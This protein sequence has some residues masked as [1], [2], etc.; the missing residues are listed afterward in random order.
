MSTAALQARTAPVANAPSS[1]TLVQ[2]QC[3]CGTH[4][5]GGSCESCNH[6]KAG[7]QRAAPPIVQDVLAASG[8]PL[9][10]DTRNRMENH[11]ARDFSGVRVHADGR[12]DRSAGELGARAWTAGAHI[13]FADG[14][15]APKTPKGASLL[16]HELGHVVQQAGATPSRELLVGDADSAHEHEA[17]E[18][19]AGKGGAGALGETMVQR[20]PL[21]GFVNVLLA[22]PHLFGSE[23]FLD[24][25]LKEYLAGLKT[26]HAPQNTTFSDNMARACVTEEAKFGPYDL[27]TK[28][29]LVQEMLTGY[30]SVFDENSIIK[31]LRR[32]P[33]EMPQI[34]AKIGREK[35]WSKFS[36]QNRRIIEALTMTAAD[37]GDVLV[38]KLRAMDASNIQDYSA[39]AT[40]PAVKEA[41]RKALALKKTTV[42]IPSNADVDASGTPST[43]INGVK[44]VALPDVIDPKVGRHAYTEA[45][46]SGSTPSEVSETGPDSDLPVGDPPP[47]VLIVTIHS[48]FASEEQKSLPSKYGVGTRPQDTDKSLQAHERGHGQAWFDFLRAHAPPVFTGKKGM[49]GSEYNAAVKQWEAAFKTYQDAAQDFALKAG[50]CVGTL[51]TDADY[52]GTGFKASICHEAPIKP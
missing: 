46:F 25:D 31:L 7:L 21:S 29:L 9:A 2:R 39:N 22:I 6:A 44:V 34:V 49:K 26:R 50:D 13:A 35:L 42:P 36:G 3:G 5:G 1:R 10:Q 30:T 24:E 12:A 43:T 51:P 52:E 23:L 17:D 45:K 14:Q 28:T 37:A 33:T 48:I 15:Y 11:F 32:S 41:A 40:D 8:Q 4:I 18:L 16:A 19:A 20:S 47:V 27:E 38:T